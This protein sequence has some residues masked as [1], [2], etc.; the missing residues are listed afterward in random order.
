M[1]PSG[2]AATCQPLGRGK[3]HVTCVP[4]TSSTR[5]LNP[6]GFS[7][8]V[9]CPL[10]SFPCMVVLLL[11]PCWAALPAALPPAERGSA[12]SPPLARLAPACFAASSRAA[13][14]FNFSG[15]VPPW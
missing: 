10:P 13:M 9:V 7:R 15:S 5:G 6:F 1:P 12:G 14:A 4:L 8:A 11:R 3:L 2:F